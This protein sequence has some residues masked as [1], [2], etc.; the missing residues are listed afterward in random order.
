MATHPPSL[1]H[2][3]CLGLDPLA[4]GMAALITGN[5]D[6]A[7]L[8]SVRKWMLICW[9]FLSQGLILGSLWAY[10][11]LGWGGYWGWDPVENAGFLPWFTATAFLHSLMIQER[12]GMMKIWNVVLVILTFLLTMIGTFMTRSASFSRCMRSAT[13]PS[14]RRAS[15]PSSASPRCSASATSSIGCRCCFARGRWTR[16]SREFAFLVNNWILLASAFFILVATLFPTLSEAIT[17]T[18]SPS[19]RRFST[20]GWAPLGWCCWSHRRRSAHRV[21]RASLDMLWKQFRFP[22]ASALLVLG[23]VA[24]IWPDRER[25][26]FLFCATIPA[27]GL[28]RWSAFRSAALC[29][30]RAGFVVGTRARQSR[31]RTF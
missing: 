26:T 7:W 3:L 15:S 27:S 24:F 12:R 14:W 11:V 16:G 10:H 23:A 21:A 9:Y 19:A 29:H 17:R 25:A 1:S 13:I 8:Q 2:R 30:H 22:I 20:S 28:H 4:F 18:A 31:G 6:D 5:L